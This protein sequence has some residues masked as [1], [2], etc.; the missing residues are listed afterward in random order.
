MQ[1]QQSPPARN[2]RLFG[3]Q[4][5]CSVH[6]TLL[7][8]QLLLSNLTASKSGGDRRL[9]RNTEQS[10][11]EPP[12]PRSSVDFDEDRH[13]DLE[14]DLSAYLKLGAS[15]DATAAATAK[16][17]GSAGRPPTNPKPPTPT[18][19]PPA[20]SRAAPREPPIILATDA[21]GRSTPAPTP[22]GSRTGRP[23]SPARAAAPEPIFV[24]GE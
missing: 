5:V 11:L 21:T 23:S 24:K 4:T 8:T 15:D 6:G 13:V 22:P 2:C 16:P 12:R 10:S 9:S 3:S 17:T 7:L 18:R 20:T 1:L 19:L 14:D